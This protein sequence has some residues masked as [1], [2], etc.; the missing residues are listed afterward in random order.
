VDGVL[1][2]I[3]LGQCR[4]PERSDAFVDLAVISERRMGSS[5]F[6]HDDGIVTALSSSREILKMQEEP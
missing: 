5:E 2:S 3:G 1:D 6:L 4:E